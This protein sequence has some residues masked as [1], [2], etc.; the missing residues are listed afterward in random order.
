ML[1]EELKKMV[2]AEAIKLAAFH[3]PEDDVDNLLH[4]S[5]CKD[6]F[7]K[8]C[9]F[10]YQHLQSPW[11]EV[12]SGVLPENGK[13]VLVWLEN[14]TNI[15]IQAY[16]RESDSTWRGSS[17]VRDCMQDGYAQ[18]SELQFAP[19]HWMRLPKPPQP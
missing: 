6:N 16:H 14:F 10:M 11:I 13:E 19:S 7:I 17:E 12:S 18:S 8:G 2:E 1:P 3:W 15:P 5:F 4:Y 9:E